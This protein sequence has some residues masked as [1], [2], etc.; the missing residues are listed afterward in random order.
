MIIGVPKEIKAQESRVGLTPSSVRELVAQGHSVLVEREAGTAIGHSD[1][2]YIAA[3]GRIAPSAKVVW[4]DASMIIKVKEPQPEEYSLLTESHI[5]FTYLHLAANPELASAL[6]KSRITALAYETVTDARRQ[7]PLLTP[8]SEIAGRMAIQAAARCLELPQ[9][10]RG[11][12]LGGVPGVRPASVT[13]LGGGIV[14]TNAARMAV[15]LGAH[16][17]VL[18][19]SLSRLRY[20]DDI[21]QGRL[22]TLYSTQEAIEDQLKT[23]DVVVGAVLSPGAA[24]PKLVTRKHLTLMREGSVLVDVSIDQGGCFET[25][26]PTT[27]ADPSYVLDQ[28]VHYCVSNIPGAVARTASDA[29]NNAT[30]PYI[31]RLADDGLDAL[32]EP[33]LNLG[34]NVYRGKITHPAVAEALKNGRSD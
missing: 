18:D 10:G 4:S 31:S 33:G 12:L 24:A 9:S 22:H 13:I 30:L 28:V 34:L 5:L 32:Q 26:R 11:V 2:D 7:L 8:M 29:L 17:T 6:Q 21:F 14:G 20:L 27:H 16:V 1:E 15:G 25:S 3:G 19:R 23:S